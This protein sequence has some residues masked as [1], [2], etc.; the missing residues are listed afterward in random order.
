MEHLI[1]VKLDIWDT[2]YAIRDNGDTLSVR[3]PCRRYSRDNSWGLGYYTETI[4]NPNQIALIRKMV[5]SNQLGLCAKDGS[6]IFSVTDVIHGVP[7]AYGW[8]PED[9]D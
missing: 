2:Y 5:A 4:T 3:C 9:F 8:T 7:N 6:A 1:S